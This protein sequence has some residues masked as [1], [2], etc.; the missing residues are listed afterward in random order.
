MTGTRPGT[1]SGINPTAI[2]RR[3]RARR[4]GL[5]RQERRAAALNVARLLAGSS[6]LRNSR[7]IACYF[8]CNGEVD[9]TA[10]MLR[11]WAMGKRCYLPVLNGIGNKRLWFATYRPGDPLCHNRFGIPEPR[12]PRHWL[13]RPWE[14]DLVLAP[15]VAFDPQ[16]NRLGMGGGYYDR[17]LAHLLWRCHWR[18]PRFYGVAY[19]FQR[20]GS[21]PCRSWD[22]PMEGLVTEQRLYHF[23]S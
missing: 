10:V 22:V 1:K 19:E 20:V 6:L 9:L 2:R 16:G 3:M 5:S 8:P 12:R 21:L 11:I 17:T 14:L 15:V 7:R 4:R 13:A 23:S 18:K